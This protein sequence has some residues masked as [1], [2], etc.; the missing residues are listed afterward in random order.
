[1]SEEHC[2]T[3]IVHDCPGFMLLRDCATQQEPRHG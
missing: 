3:A 2:P 1:M